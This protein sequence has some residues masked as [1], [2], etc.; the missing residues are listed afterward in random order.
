MA[1]GLVDNDRNVK[2]LLLKTDARGR[3][4]DY[5]KYREGGVT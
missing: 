1:R 5:S 3:I 2:L 4:M